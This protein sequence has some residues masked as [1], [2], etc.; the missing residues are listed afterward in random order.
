MH[1]KDNNKTGTPVLYVLAV[2]DSDS[3]GSNTG[4]IGQ[5]LARGQCDKCCQGQMQRVSD[6]DPGPWTLDELTRHDVN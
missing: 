6:P 4:C 3:C 2:V 1:A 5:C